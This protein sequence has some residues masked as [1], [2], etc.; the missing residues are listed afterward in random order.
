MEFAFDENTIRDPAS[1]QGQIAALRPLIVA[2]ANLMPKE[3]FEESFRAR[4]DALKAATLQSPVSEMFF[5]GIGD[6][7]R[8]IEILLE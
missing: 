3:D 6:V 1:V 8:R 4:M 5:E 7:E 2:V